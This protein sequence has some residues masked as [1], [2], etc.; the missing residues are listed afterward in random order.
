M[1]YRVLF[2]CAVCP[3]A[4][5]SGRRGGPHPAYTPSPLDAVFSV[6]ETTQTAL[7]ESIAAEHEALAE[8]QDWASTEFLPIH[9]HETFKA[10]VDDSVT[11]LAAVRTMLCLSPAA[12]AIA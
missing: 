6:R 2:C 10:L 9:K 1:Y 4:C 5:V 11:S 8:I 12:A 7:E 3:C